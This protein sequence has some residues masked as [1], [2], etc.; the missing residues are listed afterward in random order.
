MEIGMTKLQA[1]VF[2]EIT[3]A[4]KTPNDRRHYLQ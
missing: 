4:I 2:A 3:A 1:A